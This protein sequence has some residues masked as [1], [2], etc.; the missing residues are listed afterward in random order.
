MFWF[1]CQRPRL[2]IGGGRNEWSAG[3]FLPSFG[4]PPSASRRQ[5]SDRAWKG[6]QHGAAVPAIDRTAPV[7][8][9][10]PIDQAQGP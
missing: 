2:S 6:D 5:R 10:E 1:H 3:T 7:I 4:L 8:T 9:K